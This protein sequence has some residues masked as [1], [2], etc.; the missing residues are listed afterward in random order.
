M[1]YRLRQDP[2]GPRMLAEALI[3]ELEAASPHDGDHGGDTSVLLFSLAEISLMLAHV[4]RKVTEAS[5][6]PLF[7]AT[8]DDIDRM[9]D[10]WAT[11][12]KRAPLSK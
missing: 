4:A 2:L 3:R 10:E 1:I 12:Y 6:R 9:S 5:L 7:R 11:H 8:V